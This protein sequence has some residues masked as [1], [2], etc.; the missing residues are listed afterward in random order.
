MLKEDTPDIRDPS[1]ASPLAGFLSIKDISDTMLY[2]G[3]EQANFINGQ[4]IPVD[5]GHTQ[6]HNNYE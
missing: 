5:R 4:I 3:S 1:V 2:L 6:T